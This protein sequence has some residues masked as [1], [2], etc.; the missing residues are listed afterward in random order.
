MRRAGLRLSQEIEVEARGD[1]ER[2]RTDMGE[3]RGIEGKIRQRH[4]G[5]PEMRAARA[6]VALVVF[7]PHARGERP[8]FV[9]E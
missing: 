4:H 5:G 6:Q 1:R 3:D 9:H 7:H 2:H 8:D